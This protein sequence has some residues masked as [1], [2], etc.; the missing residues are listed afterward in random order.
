MPTPVAPCPPTS[1]FVLIYKYSIK[2][3]EASGRTLADKFEEYQY[4]CNTNQ[5]V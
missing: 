4:I 1:Q 2:Y 5:R 3:S